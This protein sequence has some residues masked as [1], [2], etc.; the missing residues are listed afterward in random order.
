MVNS[1]V[2][3][4]WIS[5][6]PSFNKTINNQKTLLEGND[7]LVESAKELSSVNE[8]LSAQNALIFQNLPN[9]VNEVREGFDNARAAAKSYEEA[10]KA[11][12]RETENLA[13]AS[14]DIKISGTAAVGS[15]AA[16]AVGLTDVSRGISLVGQIPPLQ[17]ALRE[18][19]KE[20]TA[21]PVGI[22]TTSAA[23]GIS[24]T[25][26]L[27]IGIVIAA[28]AIAFKLYTDKLKKANEEIRKAASIEEEFLRLRDA[29]FETTR[30]RIQQAQQE[31]DRQKELQAQNEATAA[32]FKDN[33]P[34]DLID[35]FVENQ[36]EAAQKL[37][38]ANQ[39]II[40]SEQELIDKAVEE[41]G[42]G[43]LETAE[44]VEE[45]AQRMADATKIVLEGA[46][47]AGD[48]V[49][50][51]QEAMERGVE[52]S[53]DRI[54]AIDKETAQIQAQLDVLRSSGDKSE[55]VVD[56]ITKLEKQLKS[57]G[58]ESGFA[59]DAIASGAAAAVD[60]AEEAKQAAKDAERDQ[61]KAVK[62]AEKAAEK[63]VADAR[64]ETEA[65]AKAAQKLVDIQNELEQQLIDDVRKQQDDLDDLQTDAFRDEQ[66]AFR[67]NV[68]DFRDLRKD[69]A[70]DE[71]D[72]I[73]DRD[74]F[75]LAELR[76][77]AEEEAKD[78]QEAI[79]AEKTERDIGFQEALSDQQTDQRRLRR[80]RQID[81][82]R[83]I[84]EAQ[85]NE[86]QRLKLANDARRQDLKN[87]K[88]FGIQLVAINRQAY[89]TILQM[90]TQTVSQLRRG[91]RS[92]SAS[93]PD[94]LEGLGV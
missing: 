92:A 42:P 30:E 85:K 80:E 73:K 59:T 11:A 74:V 76:R 41:F 27:G 48:A 39:E 50:F 72:A 60:A 16:Q 28:G 24:T 46:T 19:R 44:A 75:A 78:K 58:V 6:Q 87:A 52:A 79:E 90:G 23:L 45:A 40:D 68:R 77:R 1:D 56:Q 3:L 67:E 32:K 47:A 37:A 29:G 34:L 15:K 66:K 17:R 63:R 7:E 61:K 10:V 65:R 86:Q 35:L 57:L 83:E 43:V 38:D 81:F 93:L 70:R 25:A 5:D 89:D 20:F 2:R 94:V 62:E 22:N 69:A 12:A 13:G 84:N 53:E 33:N 88:Q 21:L 9:S 49:R 18:A 71:K 14:S 51:E 82:N 64:K 54:F 91:T 4:R 31:I 26:F 8:A 55:E 36:D